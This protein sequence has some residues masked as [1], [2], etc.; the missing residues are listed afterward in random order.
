MANRDS[1]A[2][3]AVFFLD[4]KKV[5]RH[6]LYSEFEALLDGLVALPDYT[7]EDAKAVYVV[8]SKSGK[9]TALVFFILYFDEEGRAD[10]SW[11]VP[12]ERLAE[13][14]GRGP[15]LG[16][17]PIRL[18]CR[19][20]CAVN[21]HQNDLWD[22]D[23]TP[24]SN[25]F[26]LIKKAVEE[27]RLRF[28]F[29]AADA[30]VPVLSKANVGVEPL[31]EDLDFDADQEKRLKLARL[32]KEQRLRIRTLES[33]HEQSI[34]SADREQ[35]IS[36][37]AYKNEIQSLQQTVEQLKLMNEK[38]KDKLSSR[39]DQFLSLQDKVGDQAALV[40]KLEADLKNASA[41]ERLSLEK[42]KMEAEIVLLKEQLDRKDFE[43]SNM[44]DR[45]EQ[46]R[47]ELEELGES[48]GG[49][50]ESSSIIKRLK[51]LEVVFVVYHPGAGHITMTSDEILRYV[52]NPNSFI[53][54]KCFVTEAQYL[55]W[56]EHFDNPVCRYKNE[57]GKVCAL[58][59]DKV[60]IPSEF[61][62]GIDDRCE[63]HQ[64]HDD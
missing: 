12:V 7:D 39:N 35:M 42:Q 18:A 19:G 28:S 53:A 38:L 24:G 14:S 44:A 11:N 49:G 62:L 25:D 48:L 33:S 55:A 54:A 51:E 9:I 5:T 31:L 21:W 26:L 34:G 29:K 32:L 59:V 50:A 37:H 13:V 22:P 27:N 4:N 2:Y 61:E 16:G 36:L 41:G 10:A 8:I 43:L 52:E 45:E 64:D 40:A 57:Q 58:Q 6:M 1:S 23:M 56:L 15:D 47:A 46:L 30:E 20:Q 17:G 60:S 3:E 63:R